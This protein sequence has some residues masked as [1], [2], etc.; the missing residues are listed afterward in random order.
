MLGGG[1]FHADARQVNVKVGSHGLSHLTYI[2]SHLWR[3]GYDGDIHIGYL[4]PVGYY[5]VAHMAKEQARVYPLVTRISV[6]KMAAYIAEG[7]CPKESI[8]EGMKSHIGI[9]MAKKAHISGDFHPA[10][11]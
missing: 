9:A 1:G 11:P 2:W 5:Q 10:K 8:A 3:L 7:G 6:G 4:E